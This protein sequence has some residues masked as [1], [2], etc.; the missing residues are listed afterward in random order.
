VNPIPPFA[1]K[2]FDVELTGGWL[3]LTTPDV[4]AYPNQRHTGVQMLPEPELTSF[5]S[6]VLR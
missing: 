3:G 2:A 1:P 4:Q 6:H 5:D